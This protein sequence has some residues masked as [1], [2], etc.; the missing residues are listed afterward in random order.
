MSAIDDPRPDL[1]QDS[2]LWQRLL[3]AAQALDGDEP[4]GLYRALDGFRCCGARLRLGR[5]T[6]VL[7]PGDIGQAEYSTWRR[8]YLQAHAETLTRLLRDLLPERAQAAA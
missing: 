3:T 7:L 5:A 4:D 6:A 2:S 8:E 1:Y